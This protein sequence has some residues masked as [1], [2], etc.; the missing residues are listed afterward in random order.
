M[1]NLSKYVYTRLSLRER[2]KLFMCRRK[3]KA[4]LKNMEIYLTK[5]Y[6]YEDLMYK[7]DDELCE[8]IHQ[9]TMK[10]V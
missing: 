10:Y 7:T 6:M 2:W 3:A 1:M 9:L 4:A 5:A 8:Y